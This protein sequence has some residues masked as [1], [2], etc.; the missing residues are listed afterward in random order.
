[1]KFE[2]SAGGI[3]F[4]RENNSLF[5]L[6]SQHSQH[7]GWVFPKGLIGDREDNK[8][9]GKEE[10]A[11][12]EVKEETG[13]DAEIIE[14]IKPVVYWYVFDGEKRKKTVY[15]Y[16]MK[17]IGGDFEERDDEMEAVEWF[18]S[19]AVEDKLTYKSDKEVWKEA[20]PIIEK[21]VQNE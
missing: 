2:F 5:I 10:T 12:R 9:Q 21:L 14:A 16:I 15:Y 8:H 19:D 11:V 7:H 1:M 18:P 17:Y 4:K 20:R 6:V 13:I 3:V